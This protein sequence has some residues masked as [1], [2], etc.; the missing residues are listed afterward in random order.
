VEAETSALVDQYLKTRDG[1]INRFEKKQPTDSEMKQAYAELE[2]QLKV[3]IGPV[4]IDGSPMQGTISLASLY[5]GDLGF[6]QVDGLIRCIKEECIF[7]TTLELLHSYLKHDEKLPRDLKLLSRNE[8]IYSRTLSSDAAVSN[9]GE[10]PIKST[11]KDTYVYAFLGLT[12][13]DIGPWVPDTL[14]VFYQKDNHVFFVSSHVKQK[15]NQIPECKGEW[16]KFASKSS[17]ALAKYDAS[18]LKDKK[19]FNEHIRYEEEG[20][21]A[22]RGCFAKRAITQQFFKPLSNHVQS[23]VDRIQ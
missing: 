21:K 9:F 18:G 17:D 15:I 7:A 20:Y 4:K 19:A 14:F 6:G 11:A 13:Q 12:A 1:F 8:E 22:Y 3:I 23:I 2:R 5:R 16:D 10:I